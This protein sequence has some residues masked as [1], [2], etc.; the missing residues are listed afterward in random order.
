MKTY[1]LKDGVSIVLDK[2]TSF[3]LDTVTA[4]EY[5][6][7]YLIVTCGNDV[8]RLSFKEIKNAKKEYNRIEKAINNG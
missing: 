7:Y 8:K 6:R 5:R 3:E 1:K 2:V 4:C